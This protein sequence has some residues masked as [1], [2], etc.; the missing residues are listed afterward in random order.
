M[1]DD[2]A[3]ELMRLVK[4]THAIVTRLEKQAA[5]SSSPG[6][7]IADDFDLDGQYGNE[8]I[9]KS[10]SARYWAGDDHTG[11]RMSE[12]SAEFLEA[13]ARYKDACAFMAAKEAKTKPEKE[14]YVGYDKKSAARARGWVKRIKAGTVRPVALRAVPPPGDDDIPF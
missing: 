8:V 10:P 4:S 6:V 1:T 7:E 2:E 12:C 13:Y 9:R 3:H 11:A 5:S 14:K